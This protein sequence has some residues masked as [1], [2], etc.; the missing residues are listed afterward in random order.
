[1]LGQRQTLMAHEAPSSPMVL[2]PYRKSKFLGIKRAGK[3]RK[4]NSKGQKPNMENQKNNLS[5]FFY[6]LNLSSLATDPQPLQ[7]TA[8]H[9]TSSRRP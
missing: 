3:A 8:V 4:L 2:V 7:Y 9:L 6:K 1:M 5:H